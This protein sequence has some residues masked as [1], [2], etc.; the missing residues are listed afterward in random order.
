[1]DFIVIDSLEELKFARFL[2]MK[3]SSE[4]KQMSN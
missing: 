2:R 3:L 4:A 1:V